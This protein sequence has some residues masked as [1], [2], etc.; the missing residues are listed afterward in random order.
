MAASTEQQA[1][2][3]ASGQVASINRPTQYQIFKGNSA[4]RFQIEKPRELYKVGCLYLQTAPSKGKVE[5][6]NTYD[7]ENKKI[8]VKFGINDISVIYHKL[9][10]N[11]DVELFH[12]FGEHQKIVKFQAKEGGGYFL[13]VTEVV[14][15]SKVR[16]SVNV[17]IS[18]EETSTLTALAFWAIPLVH[19]WM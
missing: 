2:Y 10:N 19:N 6:N 17:P 15:S 14:K 9:K 4:A 8:S 1:P 7:W 11:E 13:N 18:A 5:G 3:E 12:D 16:N